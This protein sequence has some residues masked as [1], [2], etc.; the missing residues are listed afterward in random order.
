MSTCAEPAPVQARGSWPPPPHDPRERGVVTRIDDWEVRV[1]GD[2]MFSYFVTRGLWHLQ[3]WQPASG[4][5]ILSPSRLTC[6]QYEVFPIARWKARAPSYARIRR[7]VA[8]E[9]GVVPPD[10]TALKRIERA[11]VD[12]VVGAHGRPVS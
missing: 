4:I 2:R 6:G 1:F 8:R 10:P 3:L 12:D 7:L 9:H 11:F 5:S